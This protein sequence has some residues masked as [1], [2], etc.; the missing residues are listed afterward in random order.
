MT[1][2]FRLVLLAV[3]VAL[4]STASAFADQDRVSVGGDIVVADGTTA[5]DVVCV[6]CNIKVHGQ[7][8][9][10]VVALLGDVR[11]DQ[12]RSISGDLVAI[13]GDVGLGEQ[14]AIDGDAVVIA[15]D[16]DLASGA[17]VHGDRVV[18]SGRGWL[19]L[20]F[21]PLMILVGIIWLIVH[22]VRRRRYV[23]PVYPPQR[24]L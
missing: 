11:V 16:L 21:A 6:F 23:Y 8:R 20:P 4:F 12:Q 5:E 7:V 2:R 19:L 22:L 1:I 14:S 3:F 13:G 9:G 18:Q 17:A 10:D 24:G 15:G